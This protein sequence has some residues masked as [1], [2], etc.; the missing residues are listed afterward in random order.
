MDNSI[1]NF[2]KNFAHILTK[3]M[4]EVPKIL[5]FRI[6]ITSYRTLKLGNWECKTPQEK[7]LSAPGSE[8][9]QNYDKAWI[10]TERS[11]NVFKTDDYFV[12][13]VVA[14]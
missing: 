4:S 2:A 9:S 3:C 5:L 6:T 14:P 10:D 13:F 12:M 1:D 8:S 11:D 7:I